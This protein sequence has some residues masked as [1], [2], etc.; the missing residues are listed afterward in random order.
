MSCETDGS[1]AKNKNKPP[2]REKD[3]EVFKRRIIIA[4]IIQSDAALADRINIGRIGAIH[5]TEMRTKYH[6]KMRSSKR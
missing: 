3:L 2:A 4:T 5:F 1:R 6:R